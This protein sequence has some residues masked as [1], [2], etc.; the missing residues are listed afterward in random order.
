MTRQRHRHNALHHNGEDGFV[1]SAC[2]HHPRMPCTYII[3]RNGE[4]EWSVREYAYR[5]WL[6]SMI[7]IAYLTVGAT[8]PARYQRPTGQG[9][10]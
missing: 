3:V 5:G 2:Y 8:H 7:G 1:N 4:G 9:S 10:P 6:Q